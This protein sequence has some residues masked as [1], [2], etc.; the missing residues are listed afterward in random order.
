MAQLFKMT[1]IATS[2]P[3]TDIVFV[4]SLELAVNIGPDRWGKARL[5][6]IRVSVYLHLYQSYLARIGDSDDVAHSV[7]YGILSKT[8]TEAVDK[9]AFSDIGDLIDAVNK[10]AFELAEEAVAA[11]K[12][13][14][15]SRQMILLAEGISFEVIT[16]LGS[17][18]KD[19]PTTVTVKDLILPIIIGVNAP[20][21][22]EKQRVVI[23][24]IFYEMPRSN[25]RS[26]V[27]YH[28]LTSQIAKARPLICFGA[29]I[30]AITS[31]YRRLKHPLT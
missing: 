21:R 27:D 7:H 18:C 3:Q 23:N 30:E 24:I 25:A 14:V 28:K 31:P 6:P 10:A 22:E 9:A 4:S 17:L 26:R 13:V 19:L 2:I 11:V 1:N 16:P 20:E 5:Q 29:R 15:D 12:V 8:V